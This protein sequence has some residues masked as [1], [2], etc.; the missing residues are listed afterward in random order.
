MKQKLLSEEPPAQASPNTVAFR[1]P[2][3]KD[4]Q[5]IHQFVTTPEGQEEGKAP[6][7][8]YLEELGQVHTALQGAIPTEGAV[9]DPVGLAQSIAQQAPNDLSNAFNTVQQLTLRLDVQPKRILEPLLIEPILLAMQGV[10]NQALTKINAQW[11]SE[12]YMPCQQTIASGYP[13]QQDGEDIA[14]A[15]ISYF[16]H[17]QNG[18]L[19]T[20]FDQQLKPFV[21]QD[22]Q[23]W[24]A[25][26]WRGVA[27]PVDPDTL[28]SLGYARFLSESLFSAGQSGPSVSFDL[29]PYPDQ[30][31]SASYVSQIRLRLGD[32]DFLYSM[33]PQVWQEMSWPGSS[34]S[35]GAL[36]Q[37]KLDGAW[38]PREVQGWW[39]FFRLLETAR[40]QPINESTFKV[41]WAFQSKSGRPLRIQYDLKARSSR[42]PFHLDFFKRFSCPSSLIQT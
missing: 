37:I 17:P 15:D 7:D 26:N 8:Q 36:L 41:E 20:F 12:V 10:T 29:F 38:E 2:V 34:G 13:F 31:P 35:A 9:Q 5:S 1:D 14:L 6:L 21:R 32:Q 39:G 30:G 28:E 25:K 11:E 40:V 33:G 23:R 4:F 24:Q 19:W 16:F 42:N 27:L 3:Y 18:I 22:P